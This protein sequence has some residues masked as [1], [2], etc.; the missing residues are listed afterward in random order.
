LDWVC[1]AVPPIRTDIK[2]A[3]LEELTKEMRGYDIVYVLGFPSSF[4]VHGNKSKS[5]VSK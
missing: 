3:R 2:A 1:C 4:V 5:K